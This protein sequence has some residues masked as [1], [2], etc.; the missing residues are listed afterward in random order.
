MQP[1]PCLVPGQKMNLCACTLYE[2]QILGKGELFAE[3]RGWRIAG[4]AL[5]SPDRQR[6]TPDRLRQ[7]MMLEAYARQ[8]EKQN[9]G[10]PGDETSNV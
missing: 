2:W 3:W 6:I 9:A 5:I 7:L 8:R 1:P 4:G 10:L